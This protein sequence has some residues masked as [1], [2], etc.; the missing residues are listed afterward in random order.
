MRC[1]PADWPAAAASRAIRFRL[2]QLLGLHLLL[3]PQVAA[4]Q[5]SLLKGPWRRVL[6][7]SLLEELAR[8]MKL[9]LPHHF[10]RC[11]FPVLLPFCRHF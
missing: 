6:Q 10:L 1:L 7:Q 2:T 9:L 8:V 3:A 11:R 5:A 4:A